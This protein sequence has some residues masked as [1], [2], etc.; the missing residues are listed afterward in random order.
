MRCALSDTCDSALRRRFQRC[1][2]GPKFSPTLGAAPPA[3]AGLTGGKGMGIPDPVT[4]A[5]LAPPKYLGKMRHG[6]PTSPPGVLPARRTIMGDIYRCRPS[7]GA[8]AG[9]AAAADELGCGGGGSS[10]PPKRASLMASLAVAVAV[11]CETVRKEGD[12]NSVPGIRALGES[13]RMGGAD[14]AAVEAAVVDGSIE[15]DGTGAVGSP[16]AELMP[17]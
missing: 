1:W 3:A 15:V 14:E 6:V 7:S 9:A 16:S 5:A 12:E 8:G 10:I 4:A 17:C 2:P 11:A 13:T